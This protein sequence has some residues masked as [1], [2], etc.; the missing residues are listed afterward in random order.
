MPMVISAY[1]T[2]ITDFS[3]LVPKLASSL[4]PA[5]GGEWLISFNMTFT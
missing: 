2:H 1:L 5:F 3:D 4:H